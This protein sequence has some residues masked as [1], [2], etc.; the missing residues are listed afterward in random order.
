MQ[1]KLVFVHHGDVVREGD[2]EVMDAV[3]TNV[4][5]VT[6]RVAGLLISRISK[7]SCIQIWLIRKSR[8]MHADAVE[9][10]SAG[11]IRPLV[12]ICQARIGDADRHRLTC[13]ESERR[14]A[15]PAADNRVSP[16][17]HTATNQAAASKGKLGN[18]RSYESICCIVSTDRPLLFEVVQFLR[19]ATVEIADKRIESGRGVIFDLRPGVVALK[20]EILIGTLLKANLQGVVPGACCEQWHPLKGPVELRIRS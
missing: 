9:H 14:R 10:L 4:G 12:P 11:Y 8:P 20:G 15:L 13:L 5:E 3:G 7:A 16:T 18:D 17:A 19:I 2:V 1:L 6:R